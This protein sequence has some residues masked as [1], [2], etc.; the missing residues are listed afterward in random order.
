MAWCMSSAA[1]PSWRPCAHASMQGPQTM[2]WHASSTTGPWISAQSVRQVGHSSSL[3]PPCSRAAVPPLTHCIMIDGPPLAL[4]FFLDVP[5]FFCEPCR[6]ASEARA[7]RCSTS[8]SC[9]TPSC[10][11]NFSCSCSC[12]CSSGAAPASAL[13][14][15]APLPLHVVT[16]VVTAPAA[17]VASSADDAPA[18][19][20]LSRHLFCFRRP[21]FASF[22]ARISSPAAMQSA[23]AAAKCATRSPS[24]RPTHASARRQKHVAMRSWRSGVWEPGAAPAP[25]AWKR[26]MAREKA[27]RA[28]ACF[29]FPRCSSPSAISARPSSMYP[30]CM[31]WFARMLR[32]RAAAC[33][34]RSG[35]RSRCSP[36]V[37]NSKRSNSIVGWSIDSSFGS[38]ISPSWIAMPGCS[39]SP[40]RKAVTASALRPSL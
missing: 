31:R 35:E 27:M 25:Q 34:G 39:A 24:L 32:S 8:T 21:A 4:P 3:S 26:F 29:F 30:A 36:I 1:K 33:C 17:A 13:P 28:S 9:R 6:S 11:H 12:S 10:S 5:L 22:R 23:F 19:A 37:S 14:L 2:C 16:L 7:V 38:S 18:A 40:A 15:F 20:F